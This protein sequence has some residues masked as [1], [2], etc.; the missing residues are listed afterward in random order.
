[1]SMQQDA[2]PS[3][4]CSLSL[5]G[6]IR[7]MLINAILAGRLSPGDP[8]PSTR[9]MAAKL[10]VSRNTV[11]I[12]Y[13]ALVAG[14]FLRSKNRS[15]YTVAESSIQE[16]LHH[17]PIGPLQSA[18]N[19]P[20]WKGKL[21]ATFTGAST[22]TRPTDW[23]KYPFPFVY[24]QPDLSLFPI[25]AWR[26]CVRQSMSKKWFNAWTDDLYFNDDPL[27]VEQIRSKVLTHRGIFARP[28]EILV[29]LGSQNALYLLATALIRP[30]ISVA[31]EN[32]GYYAAREIFT[33]AGARMQ[34][35][36]VDGMGL[37]PRQLGSADLL[38][39]TPSHQFPKNVSLSM[40]RRYRVL[41]WA[42]ETDGLIIED[43]Y[44]AEIDFS[45]AANMPLKALDRS[46]RV[47]YTGSFS[48]SILPGLRL[49][50]VVTDPELIAE[51]RAARSLM[52]R[53][54]PSNNQRA[55]ALFLALGHHGSHT[56]RLKRIYGER[57]KALSDALDNCLPGWKHQ[58]R[59]GGSSFWLEGPAH[60]RASLLAKRALEVGVV[61]EP[62]QASFDSS[63]RNDRYFRL[64]F[65][66]IAEERIAPGI[67]RLAEIA[68][69]IS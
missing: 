57:W 4:Y 7:E 58:A 32:P 16:A 6:Q 12:A 40:D 21:T 37:D 63:T 38:F 8:I 26:E 35:V 42:N 9:A 60:C 64:G 17:E 27:L 33:K 67:E 19:G 47:I 66:S 10:K 2:N 43:D 3:S 50:F 52:M 53:H 14:G 18:A 51:L 22:I 45:G 29:T 5:Q 20:D 28:E 1:M 25:D 31:M 56:S 11:S 65:S 15:G 41:E 48:K 61:I 36:Q 30:G 44:E 69:K 39:V 55:V 24:G 54:P 34:P 13:Q 46:S 23:F 49:G 68:L 62:G 59:F